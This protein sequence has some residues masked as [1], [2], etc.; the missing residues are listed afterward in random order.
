[1]HHKDSS[2]EQATPW[3]SHQMFSRVHLHFDWLTIWEILKGATFSDINNC[4][5]CISWNQSVFVFNF[6][7]LIIFL[8]TAIQFSQFQR[9]QN[10]NIYTDI[11]SCSVF[12]WYFFLGSAK[13]KQSYDLI[14]M[15]CYYRNEVKLLMKT[16]Q[17]LS[18]LQY[19][20]STDD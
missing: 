17:V 7:L 18:M 4:V 14:I 15:V 11:E 12:L 13:Q 8:Q 20:L 9:D 16:I 10:K 2:Q 3:K 6:L 19:S 5:T 1:M